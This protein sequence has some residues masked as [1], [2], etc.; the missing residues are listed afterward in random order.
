MMRD[1]EEVEAPAVPDARRHELR[2]DGLLDVSHQQ[3]AASAEAQIEDSGHVVDARAGVRWLERHAAT[4]RPPDLDGRAVDAKSVAGGEATPVDVQSVEGGVEGRV[5]RPRPVHADLGHGPDPISLEQDGQ[6]RDVILVRMRQ[7]D[8]IDAPV[9]G[10]QSFVEHD[11]QTVRVGTTVD[12]HPGPGVALDEDGIS[13]SDIEDR[14]VEAT[15][16]SRARRQP[17]ADDDHGQRGQPESCHGRWRV[18]GV[19]WVE[20]RPTRCG[21]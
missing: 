21:E 12:E 6:A 16:W 10:R 14:H 18:V 9:P 8:Q 11:Q 19:V 3:Q 5:A 13:L 15:V 17:G 4:R 20:A 1:L 7:H 2:V